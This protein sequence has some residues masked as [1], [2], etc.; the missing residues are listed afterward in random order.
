MEII[1]NNVLEVANLFKKGD[2]RDCANYKNITIPSVVI[3]VLTSQQPQYA[4]IYA[5]TSNRGEINKGGKLHVQFIY[6]KK[7]SIKYKQRTYGQY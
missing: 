6:L 1:E 3:N 4:N 5:K 7:H 2:A